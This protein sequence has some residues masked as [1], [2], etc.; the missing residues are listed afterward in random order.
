MI[1]EY[2]FGSIII[3][4]KDYNQDIEV[5]WTGEVLPW[6][7]EESH[8]IGKEDVK[9]TIEESPDL[10]IIGSGESGIAEVSQEAK[11]KILSEG[12][13]LIIEKTEKATKSFNDAQKQGRK[14]IG[15]F[16]LTC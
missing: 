2:K 8:L 15:L 3:D 6:Q 13:G 5:R 1:E 16:H 12:I 7:R 9:R 14:V 10:I 11:E 4:G